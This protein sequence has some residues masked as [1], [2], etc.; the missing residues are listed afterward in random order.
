MSETKG[1]TV[2]TS[3]DLNLVYV[4]RLS[5]L[6]PQC[7]VKS[8]TMTRDAM[9]NRLCEALKIID[10]C[11]KTITELKSKVDNLDEVL[12]ETYDTSV[13]L[14][15]KLKQVELESAAKIVDLQLRVRLSHY[16]VTYLLKGPSADRVKNLCYRIRRDHCQGR[17]QVVQ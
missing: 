12:A 7:F 9:A 10:G 15:K 1:P 8:K 17:Y 4:R 13:Q 11:Q 16:S 5:D 6:P 14:T 3:E 2:W